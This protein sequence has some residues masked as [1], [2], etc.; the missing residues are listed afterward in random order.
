MIRIDD[1]LIYTLAESSPDDESDLEAV[2]FIARRFLEELQDDIMLATREPWP[3]GVNEAEA[4]AELDRHQRRLR[5]GYARSNGQPVLALSP[6][7]ID[8][9]VT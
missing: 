8:D 9:V 2:A 1:R 6:I 7:D 3:A 5:L 4:F